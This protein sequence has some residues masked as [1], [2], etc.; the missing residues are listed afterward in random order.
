MASSCQTGPFHRE[1][2]SSSCVALK[3][4]TRKLIFNVKAMSLFQTGLKVAGFL[5]LQQTQATNLMQ[6]LTG[7]RRLVDSR[8]TQKLEELDWTS[9]EKKQELENF[10]LDPDNIKVWVAKR[11]KRRFT[12]EQ[13]PVEK[14][15]P[16]GQKTAHFKMEKY[17]CVSRFTKMQYRFTGNFGITDEPTEQPTEQ[18]SGMESNKSDI[19]IFV[20]NGELKC[21]VQTQTLRKISQWVKP[22]RGEDDAWTSTPQGEISRIKFF[23]LTLII[24][25]GS[26]AVTFK[27][28]ANHKTVTVKV[29]IKTKE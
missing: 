27:G 21:W 7:R 22:H 9:L 10:G 8:E 13:D 1:E 3:G 25:E 18:P 28:T 4:V 12:H 23:P 16:L 20:E 5:C 14:L 11:R 29:T 26:D 6:R 2:R 24:K 17:E 15:A 19:L